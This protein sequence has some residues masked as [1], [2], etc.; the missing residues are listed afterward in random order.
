MP[1]LACDGNAKWLT[2]IGR[3]HDEPIEENMATLPQQMGTY[4]LGEPLAKP[5]LGTARTA[6]DRETGALALCVAIPA[7]DERD[8]ALER[9][10]SD[11]WRSQ[12]LERIAGLCALRHAELVPGPG[13]RWQCA[14]VVDPYRPERSIARYIEREGMLSSLAA[15]RFLKLI[16]R[17]LVA[18]EQRDLHHGYLTPEQVVLDARGRPLLT[19]P[20]LARA[21]RTQAGTDR[22]PHGFLAPELLDGGSTSV[23]TDCYAAGAL[24]HFVATGKPPMAGLDLGEFHPDLLS[25]IDTDPDRVQRALDPAVVGIIRRA[26]AVCPDERFP[27]AIALLHEVDAALKTVVETREGFDPVDDAVGG[28]SSW[29]RPARTG[30]IRQPAGIRQRRARASSGRVPV[31]ARRA[32]RRSAGGGRRSTLLPVLLLVAVGAALLLLLLAS[33]G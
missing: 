16:V 11:G 1:V 6:V 30:A 24:L 8:V 19:H 12:R 10:F 9:L 5:G 7:P 29:N 4:R 23:A 20:L 22:V 3:H 15:L 14:A 13:G 17:A 2:S 18:L 32:M 26:M 25:A 31:A 33:V 27:S 28:T 21:E